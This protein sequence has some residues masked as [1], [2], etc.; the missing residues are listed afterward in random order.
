MTTAAVLPRVAFDLL[1]PPPDKY[2]TPPELRFRHELFAATSLLI[3]EIELDDAASPVNPAITL[4]LILDEAG[5]PTPFRFVTPTYYAW[6][7][8]RMKIAKAHAEAGRISSDAWETLRARFAVI[9]DFAVW[10]Y[11]PAR[12]LAAV[13]AFD[14]KMAKAYEPPANPLE[15]RVEK[16]KPAV[17][18]PT[19]ST[20]ANGK[21]SPKSSGDFI[22]R[23]RRLADKNAKERASADARGNR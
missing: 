22:D 8:T 20:G 1:V 11:G 23:L 2:A 14:P 17:S 18:K 7:H 13:K 10:R 21:S 16:P 9:H 4:D 15:P 3:R 12:I 6:L 19:P 5:K